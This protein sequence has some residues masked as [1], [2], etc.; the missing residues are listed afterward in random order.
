[1]K[2]L[3][4]TKYY[5]V[6]EEKNSVYVVK[7]CSGTYNVDLTEGVVAVSK[8]GKKVLDMKTFRRISAILLEALA[9]ITG[10][11]MDND[12]WECIYEG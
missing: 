6:W 8:G 9:S 4:T 7:D 12:F 2:L 5:E 10:T 11:E 3:K 1:M